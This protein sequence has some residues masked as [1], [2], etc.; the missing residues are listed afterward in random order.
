MRTRSDQSELAEDPGSAYTASTEKRNKRNYIP[1]ND[2][3][4]YDWRDLTWNILFIVIQSSPK[5]QTKYS[6]NTINK[7]G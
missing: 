6:I 2:Q 4:S 3:L 5:N 7:D 1:Y